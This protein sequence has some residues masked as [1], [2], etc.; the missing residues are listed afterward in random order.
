MKREKFTNHYNIKAMYFELQQL[1][2]GTTSNVTRELYSGNQRPWELEKQEL[3]VSMP[4]PTQKLLEQF[5]ITCNM[6]LN[7]LLTGF[8][9]IKCITWSGSHIQIRK[10]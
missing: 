5:S 6:G 4:V 1:Q 2:Q 10:H 8:E 7:P 3:V 9:S